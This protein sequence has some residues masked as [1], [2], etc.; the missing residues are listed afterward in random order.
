MIIGKG[1]FCLKCMFAMRNVTV[2]VL[3]Y[4]VSHLFVTSKLVGGEFTNPD[5][6][7][8]ERLSI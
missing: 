6:K 5:K 7:G 4:F 3:L 8:L 1:Q 2:N